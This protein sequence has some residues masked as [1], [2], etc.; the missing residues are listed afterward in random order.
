MMQ[1]V[2]VENGMPLMGSTHGFTEEGL[3]WVQ[4]TGET[5]RRTASV[6]AR[7]SPHELRRFVAARLQVL[8]L[9]TRCDSAV[10]VEFIQPPSPAP[11][12]APH[13]VACDVI[14]LGG[15]RARLWTEGRTLHIRAHNI[16][17]MAQGEQRLRGATMHLG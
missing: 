16:D 9:L 2:A 4:C 6:S 13:V 1:H 3:V 15:G 17:V 8:V 11:E 12:A 7:I 10:I 5:R 14:D